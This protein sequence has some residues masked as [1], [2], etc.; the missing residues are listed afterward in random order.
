MKKSNNLFWVLALLFLAACSNQKNTTVSDIPE[1]ND[2]EITVLDE[3]LVTPKKE[4][5]NPSERIINDLIHTKLEVSF[6]WENQHL[7]GKATLTLKPYF[8]PTDSLILDAKGFDLQTVELVQ[9]GIN[10][11]VDFDY[12][13]KQI[14]IVLPKEYTKDETYKIFIKYIAKPNDL[15]LGGSAAITADKGLYFINPLGKTPDKPR[16]IWT[17]G[18]TESNSCWFPTID[19][20]NERMTQEIFITVDKDFTTL[21]NGELVYSNFNAD[22]TRTDYWN[23]DLPHAPYLAMMAI[24][25]FKV[26]LDKWINPQGVEI[27]VNYYIED[28]YAN[29]VY[30]IFGNTPE[31]IQYFSEI[32]DYPFP[33]Q[34]YSQVIVRDYVSGAMENTTATIHGEF[35]NQTAREMIDGDN[36]DVISHELF[37]QWFGDLVTCESWA[38]LPLNES[39]ATYGEYLWNEHKYGL[40]EAAMKFRRS[41]DGYFREAEYDKKKLIR[42]DYEDKEDMFDGHSYNKGGQVLHML[43]NYVGD[44]AFFASLSK[45]LHDNEFHPVEIHNLRLAFE[46]VT[47]EDL[48]WFF[49]QWFLSVGHPVLD[50]NYSYDEIN[51]KETV[52]INQVQDFEISPVFKLPMTID[53]YTA[54]GMMSYEVTLK[55]KEETFTFPANQSPLLVNV[56][57][58]KVI[59]AEKQDHRPIQW[60]SY[61][62]YHATNY[63]DKY[64]ALQKAQ[65]LIETEKDTFEPMIADA[66]SDPFWGIKVKALTLVKFMKDYANTE[67]TVLGLTR[68][69]NPMVRS[70]AL[71]NLENSYGAKKY[72]DAFLEALNDPSYS[73]ISYGLIGLVA[74]DGDLALEKAKAFEKEKNNNIQGAI[75]R[76]Y[77]DYGGKGE[78]AFFERNFATANPSY[79]LVNLYPNYVARQDYETITH[80]IN[81]LKKIAKN[82]QQWWIRMS[83][84]KSLKNLQD[85]LKNKEE[86]LNKN[87][88]T[89]TDSADKASI[90]HKI[91]NMHDQQQRCE[92][93]FQEAKSK[94]TNEKVLGRI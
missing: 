77:S 37:H 20:P 32:L 62:Y 54:D 24:G 66:L 78:E 16:Q 39:F 40:D 86:E 84:F 61:Q 91:K 36:E 6:D 71:F 76:I 22:D 10:Q 14:K 89:A 74:I 4:I 46:A 29:N 69:E 12:D 2:D 28:E 52:T 75:G 90:D 93:A 55:D 70:L 25:E 31:M 41:R 47:G 80:G 43:R 56:D 85:L 58:K 88:A 81:N 49:N 87:L 26:A 73:V 59:L 13:G 65:E 38:N 60:W 33:W 15:P 3:I 35:L 21:S 82:G 64:E 30:G 1:L 68:D 34:K 42:F 57:A 19:S 8:Y 11:P 72:K 53:V 51:K 7:L 50:I 45:Y 92:E 79:Q 63:L 18:E 5:Y 94:E 48:N 83:A 23:M 67:Q 44:E 17:Q 27:P 9:P